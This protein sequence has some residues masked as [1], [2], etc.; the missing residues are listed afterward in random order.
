MTL[1]TMKKLAYI[2]SGTVFFLA[3]S[4]DL[5]ENPKDMAS[6]DMVFGSETGLQNYT[7]GF[8]NWLPGWGDAFRIILQLASGMGRCVPYQ[9][10]NGQCSQDTD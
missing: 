9:Y 10:N 1:D 8:Y 4:C 2:L 7:Y 5:T 6:T 3:V